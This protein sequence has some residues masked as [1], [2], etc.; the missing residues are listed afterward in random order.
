MRILVTGGCG[1]IGR[2]AVRHFVSNGDDVLNIDKLTYASRLEDASDVTFM[3]ANIADTNAML[4]HAKW[5]RPDVIVNFAAET[6]VDNSILNCSEFVQTNVA[7][8]A[9]LLSVCRQLGVR[10]CHISTDEVYGPASDRAFDETDALRPQNPYAATKAAADLMVQAFRNT[11]QI[12]YLIVR[13]SNNYGHGQHP[14]KFIPKLLSCLKH[15]KTFPLYGVGD[16]EREW[17][18]VEDT[19]RRIRKLLNAGAAHW[20]TEYNLSSGVTMMNAEAAYTIIRLYNEANGTKV[21]PADVILCSKDRP[22]HDRK[23]WIDQSRLDS[24]LKTMG[25]IEPYTTF[26]CGIRETIGKS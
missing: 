24:V 18:Y 9:S 25:G 21:T 8:T 12:D 22:G 17:T 13:P 26:E 20:N 6:H 4:K 5:F 11:Y 2:A 1:F 7:G 10:L 19:V 14:E 15:G 3:Q 16:Q 23:Y